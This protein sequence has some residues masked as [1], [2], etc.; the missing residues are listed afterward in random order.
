MSTGQPEP[1]THP[2]L[3]PKLQGKK[4]RLKMWWEVQLRLVSQLVARKSIDRRLESLNGVGGA[5]RAAA[6]EDGSFA[7]LTFT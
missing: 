5:G 2:S 3:C 7:E 1:G 4:A 6:S